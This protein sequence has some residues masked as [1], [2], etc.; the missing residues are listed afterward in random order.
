[1]LKLLEILFNVIYIVDYNEFFLG[2]KKRDISEK[3]RDEEY[4]KKVKERDNL[5]SLPDEV[6]SDGLN[7]PEVAKLLVNC[8]KSIENQVKELFTFHKETKDRSSRPNVFCKK[9]FLEILQNPQVNT[10]TR[11]SFLIKLQASGTVVFL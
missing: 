11:V 5:S 2:N 1:M 7:S 4:S 9:V 8:L 10:C 3:S 6:L